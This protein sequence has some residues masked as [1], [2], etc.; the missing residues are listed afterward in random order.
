MRNKIISYIL[1]LLIGT[2]WSIVFFIIPD[3]LDGTAFDFQGIVTL[4]LYGTALGIVPFLFLSITCGE[5]HIAAMVL[6][7]YFVLGSGVA[8]YAYT[9]HILLNAQILDATLH[10]N[11]QEA[12]GVVSWPL[13]LFVALNVLV[14]VCLVVW[15]W[16]IGNMRS[17]YWGIVVGLILLPIYGHFMSYRLRL[18]YPTNVYM[19]I[20][21]YWHLRQ[22][23]HQPR[24][25]L[26][27]SVAENIDADSLQVVLVIGEAVRADHIRLN[28]YERS[29]T[30]RMEQRERVLSLSHVYS[31]YTYTLGSVPYIVTPADSMHPEWADNKESFIPYYHQQGFRTAWLSNSDI[32]DTYIHFMYSADTL[33]YTKISEGEKRIDMK[34]LPEFS[35]AL[36]YTDSTTGKGLYVLHTI[37][38]HWY[39]TTFIPDDFAPFEPS[40]SNRIITRNSMEQIVNSYDNTIAYMDIVLDSLCTLL[41]DYPAVLLY[42]SDHGESLGE[43]GR[44][45][46]ASEGEELHYPAAIIWYSERFMQ[47]YPD[48]VR[49]LESLQKQPLSTAYIFPTLLDLIGLALT[50]EGE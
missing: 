26:P 24:E 20:R 21:D 12:S 17:S 22:V 4:I 16:R 11:M 1:F 25:M 19:S 2:L 38:S 7:V 18:H 47:K 31:P 48:K 37:G 33:I 28:G 5:K 14:A 39:Y 23:R 8:Y 30:P 32:G 9:Y 44:W 50:D 45:L 3:Y 36:A 27:A 40:L 35:K 13:I 10:T 34:L 46:H 41:Q 49:M 6:P 15:R 29:T 42:Q 43:N